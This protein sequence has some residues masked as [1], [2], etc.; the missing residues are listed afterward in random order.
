MRVR[1][2]RSGTAAVPYG[3]RS[4]GHRRLPTVTPQ[5]PARHLDIGFRL[6]LGE[7]LGGLQCGQLLRHRRGHQLVD[8]RPV[9]PAHFRNCPLQRCRQAQGIG[10]DSLL[11]D[12][13]LLKASGA[14]SEAS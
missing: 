2:V 5:Q 4:S 1:R 13:T 7:E 14:E 11:H 9:G 3:M 10:A 6:T 12:V 8:A